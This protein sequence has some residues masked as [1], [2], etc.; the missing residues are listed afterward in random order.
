MPESHKI[1][2]I[3][4]KIESKDV[5][6]EKFEEKLKMN[7]FAISKIDGISAWKNNFWC[8]IR[9]SNTENIVRVNMEKSK[10]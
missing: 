7:G 10:K 6:L 5:F 2:E 8:N 3:N 9:K 1:E 4:L